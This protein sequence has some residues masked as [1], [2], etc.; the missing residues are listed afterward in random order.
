AAPGRRS[1]GT[2]GESCSSIPSRPK[3][4]DFSPSG[5]AAPLTLILRQ[6]ITTKSNQKMKINLL[7]FHPGSRSLTTKFTKHT[8]KERRK[9]GAY[10]YL[11]SSFRALRV[12]RG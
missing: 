12:F 6:I 3:P 1:G 7:D 4:R 9:M 2:A 5:A 11:L 8:K 10:F